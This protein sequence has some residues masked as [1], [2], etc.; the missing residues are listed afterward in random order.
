MTKGKTRR[1][2]PRTDATRVALIEAAETLFAEYGFGGVSLRQIGLA[3]GSSNKTVVAYHFGTKEALIQAIY[4]HRLPA[5]DSRRKELLSAAQAEG[6][7]IDVDALLEITWLPLFE[8]VND[9]KCHS[10]GRFLSAMMREGHAN[11]RMLVNDQF[12]T[13]LL[14][15]NMVVELLGLEPSAE[16]Y[17]G[18]YLAATIV[19]ESLTYIDR[20]EA[21]KAESKSDR[22]I[23]ENAVAMSRAALLEAARHL[24]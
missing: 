16:L 22:Q 9:A 7:V 20:R 24:A 6:R 1:R 12:P 23:F 5:I 17:E 14:V 15:W 10:Y 13:S 21:M 8:Q 2:D 19:L 18:M 11:S 3:I 4:M